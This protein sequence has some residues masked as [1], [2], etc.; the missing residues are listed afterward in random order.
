MSSVAHHILNTAHAA[1]TAAF[2]ALPEHVQHNIKTDT[3]NIKQSVHN[4]HK[5]VSKAAHTAYKVSKQI[6]YDIAIGVFVLLLVILIIVLFSVSFQK[7]LTKNNLTVNEN[8]TVT[9]STTIAKNLT[10]SGTFTAQTYSSN[11]NLDTITV[12][13]ITIDGT[14]TSS[15][16]PTVGLACSGA[17]ILSITSGT[18]SGALNCG[19]IT[20]SGNIT[21]SADI[22]T[23]CVGLYAS[24]TSIYINLECPS[25]NNLDVGNDGANG[26]INCDTIN[27]NALGIDGT[28]SLVNSSSDSTSLSCTADGVVSTDGIICTSIAASANISSQSI[29][30][31]DSTSDSVLMQLGTDPSD[32]YVTFE[33]SSSGILL[34]SPITGTSSS[35]TVSGAVEI[36][37]AVEIA[38]TLNVGSG[39]N[40]CSIYSTASNTL[41][42]GGSASASP[43]AELICG[44]IYT[45]AVTIANSSPGTILQ[46]AANQ[47]TDY[48]NFSVLNNIL[49]I[50]FAGTDGIGALSI[51]GDIYGNVVYGNNQQLTSDYRL[52]EEIEP[53]SDSF[54]IDKLKPCSYLLKADESKT[55]QTGF[56]AHELQEIFPHLVKGEKDAEDMQYVNYIGLIAI[57]TKEL[58]SLKSV[59]AELKAD[60]IELKADNIMLKA[61]LF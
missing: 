35:T 23:P 27:C 36:A 14:S 25:S 11:T 29:T 43:S 54:S 50:D 16:T 44:S 7:S 46:L 41:S 3:Q 49:T 4:A 10:V 9:G 47:T 5:M 53:I 32:N 56:I 12:D 15:S 37:S 59:V 34:I 20:S 39:N 18:S 51:D 57:L 1:G 19:A 52:K 13:G 45:G 31:M 8:L 40:T 30:V 55:L 48:A 21:T 24:T 6:A 38:G 42:F 28:L 22:I 61:K 58:Q 60:N 26:T 17:G 33:Y 2:H